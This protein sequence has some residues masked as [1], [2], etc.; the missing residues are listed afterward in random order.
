MFSLIFSVITIN[1]GKAYS[2]IGDFWGNIM[3]TLR[4]SLG[5]F[6]FTVLDEPELKKS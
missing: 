6:D 5:D 1:K 3:T 2:K 4:L